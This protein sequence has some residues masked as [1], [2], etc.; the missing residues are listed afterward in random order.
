M[1]DSTS[2]HSNALA[3]LLSRSSTDHLVEPA[4]DKAQIAAILSAGLRAPDHG[5]MRPWRYIVVKGKHRRPFAELVT[6]AM[7]SVDPD[8]P[9]KKIEKRL[10][11]FSE[12]PMIIA[13]G[14]HIE[15]G[16]KIPVIEQEMSAAAGVMN[17]L[18][19]LHAEGFGG[20]WVTGEFADDP[21][22][23]ATIGL[24]PP[25]RLAGFLF[26][27]TPER[28]VREARRPDISDYM[29]F[30]KSEPVSFGAES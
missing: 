18:N 5:K 3:F 6:R 20:F 16:G 8:V 26:V 11:R 29:A 25:D 19:A 15:P 12:M 24:N 14:M 17:V 9:Q 7:K 30:W 4:P 23:L 22:F 10:H 2:K 13:L 1:T 27:G 21:E 28:A